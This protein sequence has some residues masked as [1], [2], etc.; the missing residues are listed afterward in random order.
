[1]RRY[2]K[3]GEVD[4]ILTLFLFPGYLASLFPIAVI[5]KKDKKIV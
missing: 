4:S 3:I 5:V 2:I 1:M